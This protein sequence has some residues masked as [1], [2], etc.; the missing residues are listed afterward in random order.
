MS[1][2][3]SL[4]RQK[5]SDCEELW[6][7]C[8][9]ISSVLC[10]VAWGRETQSR[11]CFWYLGK[12][13]PRHPK[14]C[15]EAGHFQNYFLRKAFL[16]LHRSLTAWVFMLPLFPEEDPHPGSETPAMECLK[17]HSGTVILI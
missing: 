9:L 17:E 11:V 15:V 3:C 16:R 14:S 7:I 6:N 4:S 12:V 5:V 1:L 8:S 10:Q 13:G 2:L